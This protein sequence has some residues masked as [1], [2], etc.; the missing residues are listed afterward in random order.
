[1]HELERIQRFK[2][3][4]LF[5]A[6]RKSPGFEYHHMSALNAAAMPQKDPLKNGKRMTD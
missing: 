3:T 6:S 2:I 4:S 1:M 5:S